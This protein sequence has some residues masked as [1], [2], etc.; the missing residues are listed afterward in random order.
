MALAS[1]ESEGANG[2]TGGDALGGA[3]GMVSPHTLCFSHNTRR[4]LLTT[5]QQHASHPSRQPPTSA[6]I[7]AVIAAAMANAP[8]APP[9]MELGLESESPRDP[10][11]CGATIC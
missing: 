11:G 9:P 7:D 4:K 3:E 10:V 2:P 5:R 1:L 6:E 8:P